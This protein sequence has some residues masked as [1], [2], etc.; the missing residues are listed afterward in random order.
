MNSLKRRSRLN[1]GS[2]MR[3][4]GSLPTKSGELSYAL[5]FRIAI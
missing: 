1:G 3:C 5:W 2:S 4:C